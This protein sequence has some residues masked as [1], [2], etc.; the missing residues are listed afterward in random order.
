MNGK[1]KNEWALVTGASSGLGIELARGLAARGSS[2]VLTARRAGPMEKLA[3]ELR[4]QHG[5]EVVVE[6]LDLAGPQAAEALLA[7]LDG[8]G[9]SPKVLINNAGFGLSGAFMDQEPEQ[10]RA[11]LQLD[12]VALTELSQ[13][14]GKR[15]AADGGGH[16]LLVASMAAYNPTPMLAAYGAAKAYVLSLGISLNVE[17]AAKNVGVTVLSPGLME[18]GFFEVSGYKVNDSLRRTMVTPAKVAEIGLEAMFAGRPSVIAGLLNRLANH[19]GK[20]FSRHAQAKMVF[21]MSRA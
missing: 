1:S 10:L 19:A 7:R 8:R 2:V 3:V 15:M 20:L 16:I 5:V 13:L 11:M 12:I 6:A 9:I 4:S 14:F 21:R 18:T 17:L